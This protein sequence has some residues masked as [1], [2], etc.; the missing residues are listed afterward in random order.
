MDMNKP[1]CS[2]CSSELIW[3]DQLNEWACVWC[4]Y[5]EEY[6]YGDD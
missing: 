6:Y 2:G 5:V 4:G 3:D 1:K